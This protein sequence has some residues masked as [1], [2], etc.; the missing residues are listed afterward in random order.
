MPLP[1]GM[2]PAALKVAAV[3]SLMAVWWIT[4]A[5]PIAASALLPI[6]LFP[7]LGVMSTAE[8]TSSYAHHLIYLFMGGFMI[9]VTMQKWNLHKRIAM[10][11][12]QIVGVSPNRIILG[13]MVATA[14]LSRWISNT[15]TTMMMLPIAMAVIGH[16][17]NML[18]QLEEKPSEKPDRGKPFGI[19]LIL[20]IAYA[21]S[22]GG[23][24]TLIGTPPNAILAGMVEK[25]YGHSISFVG[26]LSFGLPLSSIMLLITWA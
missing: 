1:E 23:V 11:T 21:A 20:G 12:I 22:I 3:A 26:W 2:S 9:A 5:A 8:T 7:F 15:A 10:H 16:V 19:C 18:K 24:A 13:F 25:I 4:E 17:D 14:F 6:V